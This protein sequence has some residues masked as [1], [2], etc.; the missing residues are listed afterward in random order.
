MKKVHVN[1]QLILLHICKEFSSNPLFM[2]YQSKA[3]CIYS[4]DIGDVPNTKSLDL[5]LHIEP[6]SN[7]SAYVALESSSIF[8]DVPPISSVESRGFRLN[9]YAVPFY[10]HLPFNLN[11]EAVS[12]CPRLNPDARSFVPNFLPCDVGNKKS[13]F[14]PQSAGSLISYDNNL[15][16]SPFDSRLNVDAPIFD[17]LDLT[18]FERARTS[19]TSFLHSSLSSIIFWRSSTL[20]PVSFLS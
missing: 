6:A 14:T 12:F 3:K 1:W 19:A 18:Y 15:P 11:A 9:P 5:P 13:T 17:L 8:V 16:Y 4:C 2:T 10:T 20:N 7:S